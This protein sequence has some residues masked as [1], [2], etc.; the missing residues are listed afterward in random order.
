MVIDFHTHA[1]PDAIAKR[2]ISGLVKACNNIYYPCTDGTAFD[3]KQKMKA[4]GVDISVVMPVVTKPS[5]TKTVNEWAKAIT[6]GTLISFGGIHPDTDDY[7]RDI[8]FVSS[9][10]LPGIKLHPEYQNFTV[11][12]PEMLKVTRIIRTCLKAIN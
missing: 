1:F 7:K 3:L 9:L 8:D 11:D 12:A 5:Q 6:D 2:A 10:G 4:F